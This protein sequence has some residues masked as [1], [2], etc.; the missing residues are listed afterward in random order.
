MIKLERFR[1]VLA[2]TSLLIALASPLSLSGQTEKAPQDSV[3]PELQASDPDVKAYIDSAENLG[4]DG[5]YADA[6]QQLQKAL[7]LCTQKG[8]LADKALLEA[9]LAVA[10]FMQGKLEDWK[11]QLLSAF[12]DSKKTEN[13]VLQ[14]DTLVALSASAQASGKMDEA[15]DLATR[16]LD[17]ARKSK[18]FWIQSRCL[19]ELGRL[20]ITMGKPTEARASVEEAL[21]IDRLNQYD[22]EASHLLY[23]A[24]IT[25]GEK[26]KL[27]QAIQLASSA[28]EFA[29]RH[30]NYGVFMQAST[31]LAQGYAQKGMLNESIAILERSRDGLSEDG[32]PLFQRPASYRAAMSLPYSKI[33]FL[34]SMAMAYQAGQRHDEALKS[35]QELYEVA[36]TAGVNFAAAEA[37]HGMADLHRMKKEYAQAI[38]FYSL[39]AEEWA[40]VGN[41]GRRIDALNA[42]ASL[43]A[44]QG[45]G[46]KAVQIDEEILPL[47]VS[48]HNVRLQF[49]VNLAIAE[50][51]QDHGDFARTERALKEAESLVASDLTVTNVEP[52][53]IVELYI[54]LA[55]LAEKKA[56][57]FQQLIA[58]GARPSNQ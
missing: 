38:T 31:S 33:T 49:I 13:L 4:Q 57:P 43:L 19:G 56:D 22:W 2:F 21:R 39:A 46:D 25:V 28:R 41:A 26:S 17:L 11:Q 37:A 44:A 32:K 20:Q 58:L 15:L 42:E 18:N 1:L 51:L 30:N 14:A 16:A 7:V 3:P 55:A 10:Y 23:L 27:D 34:E 47:V 12:E 9:K 36:K 54:R 35:W 5:N 6:F 48:A 40:K 8:L 29:I 50:I 52:T 53:L 24:W 45:Q